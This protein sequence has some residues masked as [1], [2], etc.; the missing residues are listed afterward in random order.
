MVVGKNATMTS[1][2]AFCFAFSFPPVA[3]GFFLYAFLTAAVKGLA[4]SKFS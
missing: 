4:L 1:T 2:R 3:L